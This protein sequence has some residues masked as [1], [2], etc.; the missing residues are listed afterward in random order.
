M[1]SKN[2]V[3]QILKCN[4]SCSDFLDEKMSDEACWFVGNPNDMINEMKNNPDF[5]DYFFFRNLALLCCYAPMELDDAEQ[6]IIHDILVLHLGMI[7]HGST[8]EGKL[9]HSSFIH[10]TTNSYSQITLCELYLRALEAIGYPFYR[11][12]AEKGVPIEDLFIK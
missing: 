9:L 12:A 8:G 7:L 1:F 11:K 2:T 4:S 3:D 5:G 10:F 6:D